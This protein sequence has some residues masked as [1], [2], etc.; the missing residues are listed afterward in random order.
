MASSKETGN[1]PK[2]WCWLP[3]TDTQRRLREALS[4]MK[5]GSAVEFEKNT[6]RARRHWKRTNSW[7]SSAPSHPRLQTSAQSRH[8][9]KVSA[10]SWQA[11][12][13][14][15]RHECTLGKETHCG[16]T[17]QCS[18]EAPHVRLRPRVGQ[19]LRIGTVVFAERQEKKNQKPPAASTGSPVASGLRDILAETNARGRQGMNTC[20]AEG[21][22]ENN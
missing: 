3:R 7:F 15:R 13:R 12:V 6:G 9:G 4:V 2:E 5:L 10:S 19:D 8:C 22:R 18:T 21:R 14:R 20:T 11:C 17:V 1:R 16:A